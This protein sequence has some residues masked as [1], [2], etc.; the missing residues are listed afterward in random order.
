[1]NPGQVPGKGKGKG[2]KGK[3]C[4][5]KGKSKGQMGH[6][7]NNMWVGAEAYRDWRGGAKNNGFQ[8]KS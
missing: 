5:S 6:G 7:K 8:G 2:K 3:N 1:M 4:K